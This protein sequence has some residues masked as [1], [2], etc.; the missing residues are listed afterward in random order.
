MHGPRTYVE[1]KN[2]LRIREVSIS[3]STQEIGWF[4][5]SM[6]LFFCRRSE[7]TSCL[8]LKSDPAC[9]DASEEDF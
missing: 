2:S 3:G 1:I 7:P 9:A 8:L 4:T 5:Q 6:R